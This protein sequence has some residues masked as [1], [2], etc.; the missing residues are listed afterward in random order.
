MA[1]S[2]RRRRPNQGSREEKIANRV[3]SVGIRD[4]VLEIYGPTPVGKSMLWEV[5]VEDK[6]DEM[7][8]RFVEETIDGLLVYDTFQQL[9]V[10]LNTIQQEMLESLTERQAKA[11]LQGAMISNQRVELIVKLGMAVVGFTVAMAIVGYL[12]VNN[13][14]ASTT[15]LAA[16]VIASILS[17]AGAYVYGKYVSPKVPPIPT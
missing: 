10:R 7:A 16:V 3:K 12:A 5:W 8:T 6:N 2:A 4:E 9:A 17:S 13:N 11:A 15:W 14:N 1:S